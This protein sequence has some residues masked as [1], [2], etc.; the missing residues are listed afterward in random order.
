MILCILISCLSG[1]GD[2]ETATS[3]RGDLEVQLDFKGEFEARHSADL[4]MPSLPGHPKIEWIIEEGTR[5]QEGDKL[6]QFDVE[7]ML[8]ERQKAQSNLDIARTKIEQQEARLTLDL[9]A[10]EQAV[11]VAELD[12]ELA[13]LRQTDSETVALVDREVEKTAFIKAQMATDAAGTSLQR[14]QLDADIELQL[15]R[16]EADDRQWKVERYDQMIAMATM[17]APSGGLVVIGKNWEGK[18]EAG[19][20]VWAGS[21][22]L[23][24][25]DLSEMQV[26]AWVHEVDSPRVAVGQ[27]ASI[28]MDAHPNDPAI[29]KVIKIA[30]LAVERGEHRIKHMRVVLEMDETA[31]RM[32]PGMTVGVELRV[33]K[34]ED[35]VLIPRGA[36]GSQGGDTVVWTSGLGGWSAAP[37]SILGRS[38][39]QVAVEGIDAGETVSL[40]DPN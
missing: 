13:G 22:I 39:D 33:Q 20:Q 32:K 18:Y 23:S 31:P 35:T 38:D 37:V 15:L 7:Q 12:E 17:T 9:G 1:T 19:S 28:T 8:K 36:I 40:G 27:M 29:A 5:V 34:L 21:V 26:V 25:P 3:T 11:V 30:D 16:L 4:V 6:V 14:V 2:V 10:A 24:L